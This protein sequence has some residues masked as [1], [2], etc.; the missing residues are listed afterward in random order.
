M[1]AQTVKNLPTMQENQIQPLGRED[2]LEKGTAPHS[3][4]LVWEI[5]RTEEPGGLQ[6]TGSEESGTTERLSFLHLRGWEGGA[7][8]EGREASSPHQDL[9]LCVYS[10]RLFL[11][12]IL[13]DKLVTV[14]KLFF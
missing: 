1:V 8:R 11:S 4:I 7:P 5:P 9:V 13:C 3:S 6:S 12:C 2:P 10:I 14:C